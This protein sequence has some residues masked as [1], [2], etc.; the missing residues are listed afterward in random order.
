M[1]R[2]WRPDVEAGLGRL[3]VVDAQIERR[4]RAAAVERELHGHAAALVEHGGDHAAVQHARLDVADKDRLVGQAG[5]GL[6]ARDA[7]DFQPAGAAVKRPA[8]GDRRGQLLERQR[9][10]II[11]RDFGHPGVLDQGC[12]IGQPKS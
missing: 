7:V 2:Q 9:L 10:P 4:N 1:R 6:A 3:L 8:R 11:G 5:P 12:R